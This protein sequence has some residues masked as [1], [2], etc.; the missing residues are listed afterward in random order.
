MISQIY[1]MALHAISVQ[2]TGKQ[3]LVVA[4]TLI[5]TKN[6]TELVAVT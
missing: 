4:R 6:V 3:V 1:F 5:A 2:L